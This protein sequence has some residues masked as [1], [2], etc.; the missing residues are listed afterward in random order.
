MG[1]VFFCLGGSTDGTKKK[2]SIYGELWAPLG[3]EKIPIISTLR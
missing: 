1:E 2:E 3:K